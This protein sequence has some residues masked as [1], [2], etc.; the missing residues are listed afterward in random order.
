MKF[1]WLVLLSI[2]SVSAATLTWDA[3]DPECGVVGYDVYYGPDAEYPSTHVYVGNVTTTEILDV[4]SGSTTYF[5][6]VGVDAKGNVSKPSN[7][8]VWNEPDREIPVPPH[9]HT[10]EEITNKPTE[11]PPASHTHPFTGATGTG[12]QRHAH[13][14]PVQQT[15]INK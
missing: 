10:W 9:T 14:I 1:S 15:G 7:M 3:L 4:E 12:T 8:V 5:K 11:F 6:V 13:P 2:G